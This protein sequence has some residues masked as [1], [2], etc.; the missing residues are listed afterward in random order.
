[1]K[2]QMWPCGMVDV[3]LEVDS[4]QVAML[5]PVAAQLRRQVASN[6]GERLVVID[7]IRQGIKQPAPE[8]NKSEPAGAS[9]GMYMVTN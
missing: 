7:V 3:H 4:A 1:M 9:S 2:G 5:F 6:G 8:S